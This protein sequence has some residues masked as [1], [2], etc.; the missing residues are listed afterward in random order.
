MA[1]IQDTSGAKP[2]LR[3][4]QSKGLKISEPTVGNTGGGSHE[5]DQKMFDSISRSMETLVT[6][7]NK[8]RNLAKEE[9]KVNISADMQ[10]HYIDATNALAVGINGQ[11]SEQLT[12]F[13]N[14]YGKESGLD[15]SYKDLNVFKPNSG[16][17]S[18]KAIEEMSP[19][20][21]IADK[22]FKADALK[23]H[24]GELVER[25]ENQLSLLE[26]RSLSGLSQQLEELEGQRVED[27][28]DRSKGDGKFGSGSTKGKV[29]N[30]L[31]GKG[32][33]DGKTLAANR[34]L[35][36][37]IDK[38]LKHK[39]DSG[40]MSP[41]KANLRIYNYAQKLGAIQ[42]EHYRG[43]DEVKAFDLAVN[44]KIVID[45]GLDGYESIVF[46]DDK[47][48]TYVTNARIKEN[49]EAETLKRNNFINSQQILFQGENAKD[50]LFRY[51]AFD[52]E[53]MNHSEGE[54]GI[55][56]PK[57]REIRMNRRAEMIYNG[58]G[59]KASGFRNADHVK[60]TMIGLVLGAKGQ[61]K[62]YD[63]YLKAEAEKTK[64]D[65]KEWYRKYFANI[66]RSEDIAKRF[67]QYSQYYEIDTTKDIWIPKKE[68]I[69]EFAKQGKMSEFE[70]RNLL[71]GFTPGISTRS[72]AGGLDDGGVTNLLNAI[73]GYYQN[74]LFVKQT[75]LDNEK[76]YHNPDP[77][78]LA[79]GEKDNFR[80]Y[81]LSPEQ[82]AMIAN[83]RLDFEEIINFNTDD[84]KM[85][86]MKSLTDGWQKI[87][88]K[89]IGEGGKKT[90]AMR[91]IGDQYVNSVLIPRIESLNKDPNGTYLKDM[92]LEV[93]PD[94][95]WTDDLMG[96]V[97]MR[98]KATGEDRTAYIS[99]V[100]KP[101]KE[102]D[103]KEVVHYIYLER[104][105]LQNAMNV[106]LPSDSVLI[107]MKQDHPTSKEKVK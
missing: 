87:Q 85:K 32:L 74:E 66:A 40:L 106:F 44:R 52:P 16:K 62:T 102:N 71:L 39:I 59:G 94:V 43:L 64:N 77:M 37:Y 42:F 90:R 86:S 67:K 27:S 63:K 3:R 72:P 89:Q 95:G 101:S 5:S 57:E 104:Q 55:Y 96:K 60:S 10:S 12:A 24:F 48:A 33:D 98:W 78:Q 79:K 100:D 93:D 73:A 1:E 68:S 58:L 88:K 26:T 99:G 82:H 13:Q 107:E 50:W 14:S 22:K 69:E 105:F 45:P 2:Q 49:S 25:S 4:Y 81:Q 47:L 23:L 6:V 75:N 11:T 19:F 41:G 91:V 70:A 21:E 29:F 80:L 9:E 38:V 35:H 51:S 17:Y 54:P 92:G 84:F 83:Y 97:D 28:G 65:Y 34:L 15:G 53:A 76:S 20:I 56:S 61:K 7:G 18:K 36:N 30:F 8:M 31:K 103:W 46:N